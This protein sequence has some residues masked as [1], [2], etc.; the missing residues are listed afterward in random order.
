MIIN[1]LQSERADIAPSAATWRTG[2]WGRGSP[3]EWTIFGRLQAQ[4]ESL[5]R[6]IHKIRDNS[7]VN[8]GM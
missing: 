6:C 7:I 3:W 2:R 5:L 8:N 4:W 1:K